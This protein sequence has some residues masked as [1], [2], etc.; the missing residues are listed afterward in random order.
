MSH[1]SSLDQK[2]FFFFFFFFFF[3]LR[4]HAVQQ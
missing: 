4:F 2:P 1:P 3:F